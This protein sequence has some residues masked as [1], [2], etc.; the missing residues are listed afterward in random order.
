MATKTKEKTP[1]KAEA[2]PAKE[3]AKKAPAK[4]VK[5]ADDATPTMSHLIG[6][7][8]W[9]LSQSPRHRHLAISDSEWF[10]LPA[11]AA[12][13][14]RVFH[15]EDKPVGLALWASVSE[16][17]EKEK[18]L[19]KGARLRPDEWKSGDRVWLVELVCPFATAENKLY[20]TMISEL[21]KTALKGK[22]LKIR[23]TDQKTGKSEVIELKG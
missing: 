9:L 23:K 21:A 8:Y 13:Q 14:A 2:K 6:E 3:A 5:A 7:I 12:R 20:E 15:A 1:A 17:V 19:K 16:D 18:F 4:T 10:F 11:L 22:T